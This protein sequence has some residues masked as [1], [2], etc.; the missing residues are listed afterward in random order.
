VRT[1]RETGPLVAAS[2]DP[3]GRRVVTA[4][5][6]HARLWY[7]A[8]GHLLAK[9][10]HPGMTAAFFDRSGQEVATAGSDG[11]V[12]LWRSRDGKLTRVL[13]VGGPV[14]LA[15]LSPDGRR[16]VV[17]T[18][19]KGRVRPRLL[20]ART[21]RL[22]RAL[23][24]RGITDIG[25]AP[26]GA[27]FA[28]ASA[29]GSTRLW[30][31]RDGAPVRVLDDG[32]KAIADFAFSPDGS[33]VATASSDGAVRVWDAATGERLFYFVGHTNPV[34]HVSFSPDGSLLVSTSSD[35]TA[36]IWAVEG[37]EL[38]RQVAL[39]AGSREAVV[40]AAFSPD[41]RSLV[42]GSEGGEARIWDSSVE[43]R[44][45]VL[46]REATTPTRVAYTAGGSRIAD[47]A[48]GTLRIR[49]ARDGALVGSLQTDEIVSFSGNGRLVAS[50]QPG[51]EVRVRRLPQGSSVTSFTSPSAVTSVGLDADGRDAVT[52]DASGEIRIWDLA[53]HRAVGHFAAGAS[54]RRV[55]LSPDDDVVLT[56][57]EDGTARLWS[58]DGKL[59]R[60]LRG[61]RTPV[62]DARFD[63]SGSRVVTAAEGQA[64]NAIVWDVATGRGTVLVGHFGTVTA[65]SFSSDGR[66]ILTAGPISAAIWSAR[67]GE[68]LFYLRGP[69]DLLTD[70]EWSPTGYHVVTAS[71]DDT[72]RTYMCELCR[73]LPA[74]E[75]WARE[76]LAVTTG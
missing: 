45:G 37:I 28:T 1:V 50:A 5:G 27:M 43:Q 51:G 68:L 18:A 69:T 44:L 41:G 52:A 65:A 73:P 47:L 14:R 63:P 7:A 42:T 64:R 33:L 23:P 74:L 71:R 32:G 39:L 13:Q 56:G 29:D 15:A 11:A 62:T 67:T 30:R 35:R 2:Y 40:S 9:L 59:L 53:A 22:L 12:R 75:A 58:H 16:V 24:Q 25:F 20:D 61:H 72:V 60:V 70:A 6:D 38:G 4:A 8:S 48:R 26:S 31:S 55:A 76:R 46:A 21:G 54:V 10:R 34:S 19:S 36:R 49:G 57:S 66:W 3:S 17:A